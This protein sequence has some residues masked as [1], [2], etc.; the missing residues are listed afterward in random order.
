MR[1]IVRWI[2]FHIVWPLGDLWLYYMEQKIKHKV[3]K[4]RNAA[5]LSQDK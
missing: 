2:M 1:W 5:F 4:K 3:W